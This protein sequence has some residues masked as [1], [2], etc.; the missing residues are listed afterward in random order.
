MLAFVAIVLIVGFI[1]AKDEKPATSQLLA[2]TRALSKPEP[3]ALLRRSDL[4]LSNRQRSAIQALD[5][6]WS[7][8][9]AKL[10]EAMSGYAPKQGRS[11]QIATSLQGYSELSRSYDATRSSYWTRAIGFL[12]SSQKALVEGGTR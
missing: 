1:Q 3:G 8:D 9:K 6:R 2:P 10:L 11:D 7:A 12:D 4:G 5:S